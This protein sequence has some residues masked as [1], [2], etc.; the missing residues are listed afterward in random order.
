MIFFEQKKIT[1]CKVRHKCLT[2][3]RSVGQRVKVSGTSPLREAA[4]E[5]APGVQVDRVIV[6]AHREREGGLEDLHVRERRIGV[7]GRRRHLGLSN[8]HIRRGTV[9][10][11]RRG[12]AVRISV[13]SGIS[14]LTACLEVNKVQALRPSCMGYSRTRRACFLAEARWRTVSR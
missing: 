5:V 1:C 6:K 2:F 12:N 11:K 14:P 7:E 10:P 4:L 8:D 3:A 13:P 9:V